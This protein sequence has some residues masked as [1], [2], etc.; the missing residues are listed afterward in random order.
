LEL[1]KIVG[2]ET[3]K[4]ESSSKIVP[5]KK[6][7]LKENEEEKNAILLGT[8]HGWTKIYRVAEQAN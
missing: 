2:V 4:M 5:N 1:T 6:G 3:K 8:V 7:K